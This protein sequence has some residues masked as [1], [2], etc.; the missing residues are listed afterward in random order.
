M[1][2]RIRPLLFGAVASLFLFLS[3]SCRQQTPPVLVEY[4]RDFPIDTAVVLEGIP[5]EMPTTPALPYRL[6][7]RLLVFGSY[8]MLYIYAYPDLRF[9]RSYQMPQFVSISVAGDELYLEDQGK[10]DVYRLNH[11]DSL[12]LTRSFRVAT[13]PYSVG[14]V[15][16]LGKDTYI[17]TGS[18][19]I[20]VTHEYHIVNPETGTWKSGGAYPEPPIRFKRLK[21][22]R[23]AYY[24]SISVKPD[25]TAFVVTYGNVR[26]IHIYGVDGSLRHSLHLDYEPNNNHLVDPGFERRIFHCQGS[27][28]TDRYIYLIN[29]EQKLERAEPHGDILVLDWDGNLKARYRLD[30]YIDGIVVDEERNVIVGCGDKGKGKGR[31]FFRL[32]L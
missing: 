6:G 30:M 1:N 2:C 18:S 32:E 3:V 11:S 4:K 5:M 15:Q 7:N 17:L 16:P 24:H 13:V 9:I 28:V 19:D 23:Y 10:V 27:V 22:F 20:D 8:N 29:P 21:D 12:L 25:Q 31:Q 14:K 26:R